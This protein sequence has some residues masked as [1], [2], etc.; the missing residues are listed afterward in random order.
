MRAFARFF[1]VAEFRALWASQALSV[2]GDR[3]ALVALTLLVYQRTH[4]PLLTAA[5]YAAGFVPWVVGGVAYSGLADRFPRREVMVS[6]D[7]IRAVLIAAMAVPGM[8][9]PALVALIAASTSFAVPFESARAALLPDILPGDAYV[10]GTAVVQTTYRSALVLGYAAGGAAVAAVGARPALAADAVTFAVSA[11]VIRLGL[12][13]RPG[14]GLAANAPGPA[15]RLAGGV[16]LVF[17]DRKLRTLMLLGWLVAF[18][19]VPEGIAAPYARSLGGGA[20]ATGLVLAATAAGGVIAAPVFTTLAGSALRLRLAGPLAVAACATLLLC[21]TRPGLAPSLVIFAASGACGVYQIPA[22]A[23]F[24]RGVPPAGRAQAFGLANAGLIA[25][26]GVAFVLAGAAAQLF[27][28][29]VVIAA[30]GGAG[31][32]AGTALALTQRRTPLP[33]GGDGSPAG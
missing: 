5:A 18:Y 20:G 30:A 16:R 21:L 25:G 31:A 27:S 23:A 8:P 1:A 33:A 19:A 7:V 15:G 12:R 2:A 11:A 14:P 10:V 24:V 32:V 9:L 29:A 28:P 22:N 13:T 17:G 3:L 26:Q 6:C 4:S